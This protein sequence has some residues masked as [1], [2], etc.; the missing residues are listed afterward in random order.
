MDMDNEGSALFKMIDLDGDFPDID[1]VEGYVEQVNYYDRSKVDRKYFY[2]VG[3]SL[4]DTFVACADVDCDGA[5]F[6]RDI[7]ELAY[8]TRKTHARGELPCCHCAD[9]HRNGKWCKAKFSIDI[10][11]KKHEQE[12]QEGTTIPSPDDR[13]NLY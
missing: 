6:I 12:P 10:K 2:R 8:G 11:Y 3:N 4:S 9:S 1:D 5:Y 13:L 7:I